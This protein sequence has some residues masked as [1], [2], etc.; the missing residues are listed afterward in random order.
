MHFPDPKCGSIFWE[1][2]SLW[3]GLC[4][5]IKHNCEHEINMQNLFF[6][7]KCFF[8]I[9]SFIISSHKRYPSW[10]H[11][12]LEC[13]RR[14]KKK[15]LSFHK[16]YFITDLLSRTVIEYCR[17]DHQWR[18]PISLCGL[19]EKGCRESCKIISSLPTFFYLIIIL[20]TAH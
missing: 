3:S 5:V 11:S 17:S 9:S 2:T 7:E 4:I 20:L 16:N 13:R 10:F 12:I 15:E 19:L 14:K 18:L 8:I 1:E 6:V